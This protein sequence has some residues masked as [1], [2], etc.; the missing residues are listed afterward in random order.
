MGRK[1]KKWN[2]SFLGSF[3]KENLEYQV[4]VKSVLHGWTWCQ[5]FCNSS[6]L[7]S[8]SWRA[9]S[10]TQCWTSELTELQEGWRQAGCCYDYRSLCRIRVFVKIFMNWKWCISCKT[11]VEDWAVLIWSHFA[12]VEINPVVS[13]GW[14]VNAD[15]CVPL[16]VECTTFRAWPPAGDMI[17]YSEQFLIWK[18]RYHR[19]E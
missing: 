14:W 1:Q 17:N 7:C 2:G 16:L 5:L 6:F 19:K 18:I 3:L 13:Q 10:N 11:W 12:G 4:A 15:P 8:P 9:C